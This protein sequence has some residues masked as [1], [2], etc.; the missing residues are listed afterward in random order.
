[1][2]GRCENCG[3]KRHECECGDFRP[4]TALFD[5]PEALDPDEDG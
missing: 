3:E 5:D 2:I 4:E 1:M